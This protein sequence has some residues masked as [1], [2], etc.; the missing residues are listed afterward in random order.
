MRDKQI[1]HQPEQ[2]IN[3]P[4]T[5]SELLLENNPAKMHMAADHQLLFLE[6]VRR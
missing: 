5:R 2:L 4:E 1:C 3:S 6:H